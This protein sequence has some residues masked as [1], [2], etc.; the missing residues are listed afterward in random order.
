MLILDILNGVLGVAA[1]LLAIRYG[2]REGARRSVGPRGR[3]PLDLLDRVLVPV[4]LVVCALSLIGWTRLEFRVEQTVE[5]SPSDR[6]AACVMALALVVYGL[7]VFRRG[8]SL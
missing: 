2:V 6:V 7:R 5:L 4:W 1:I 8:N 3:S